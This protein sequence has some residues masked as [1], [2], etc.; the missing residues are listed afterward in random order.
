MR[1]MWIMQMRRPL[2]GFCLL[3][4]VCL[5]GLIG[6]SSGFS[7]PQQT[8]SYFMRQKGGLEVSQSAGKKLASL[9][10]T[11]GLVLEPTQE[12]K[13]LASLLKSAGQSKKD[14]QEWKKLYASYSGNSPL[15]LTAAMQAALKQGDCQE[16]YQ[17]YKKLQYMTLPTYTISMKLLGKLG[18]QDEVDRLWEEL[19]ELDS[20]G[21]VPAQAR[22]DTM[23][24]NG[25][26]QGAAK[27]LDYM[28]ERRID[29]N[30]VH[31]STAIKACANA[32]EADRAKQAKALFATMLTRGIKPNIVTYSNLLRA[33]RDEPT[34]CCS[35]LLADMEEHDVRPDTVFAESFLYIFLKQPSKGTWTQRKVIE[36]HLRKLKTGDLQFAKGFID[37]L[38]KADVRLSRSCKLIESVLERVLPD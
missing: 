5:H 34:E 29:P 13:T 22:I 1:A 15:V 32:A 33:S 35:Q 20:V 23:A 38:R 10:N 27:V 37:D 25:D 14:P 31:Y 3:L 8:G 36:R 7:V 24:D 2:L 21:P 6:Q 26:M 19:V 18:Q 11:S 12:E 9:V 4:A 16:G 17:V 30:I 28:E